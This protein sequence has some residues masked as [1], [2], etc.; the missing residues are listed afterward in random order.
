MGQLSV[1]KW[2]YDHGAGDD[3]IKANIWGNTPMSMACHFG[4]LSVCKWLFSAGAAKHISKT[5]HSG[6]T[7][8]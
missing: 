1:C 5:K 2:L 4:H 7:P 3:I 8:L 6:R